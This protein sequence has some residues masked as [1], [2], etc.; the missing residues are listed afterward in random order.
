[1]AAR[2]RSDRLG[3]RSVG[4]GAAAL[5]SRRVHLALAAF[6]GLLIVAMLPQVGQN[7]RFLALL[8]EAPQRP[9]ETFVIVND[10][11]RHSASPLSR[12]RGPIKWERRKKLTPSPPWGEGG[13]R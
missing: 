8:L 11:F 1:M 3:K 13:R 10:D 2:S 5:A 4:S 6:A 9:F 12:P 7:P